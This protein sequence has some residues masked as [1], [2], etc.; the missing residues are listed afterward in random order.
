MPQVHTRNFRG[1]GLEFQIRFG[2]S[3]YT[4]KISAG[5]FSVDE[6]LQLNIH[7]KNNKHADTNEQVR[8]ARETRKILRR[9]E[10]ER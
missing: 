7:T 2:G 4:C 10:F 8:R 3:K 9:N 1:S 5:K 6:N